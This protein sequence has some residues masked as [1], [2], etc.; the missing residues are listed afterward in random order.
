MNRISNPG[1]TFT[2]YYGEFLMSPL[3]LELSFNYCSHKCAFCFANLNKPDRHADVKATINLIGQYRQRTTLAAKLLQAG[4]ATVVSNRVD[5]FAVSNDRQ[6]LPV[7]EMMASAG[8][9]VA[10]QT[11][12]GRGVDEAL[13]FLAPSVWYVSIGTLSEDVRKRIEPGAPTIADR[14]DLIAK[15]KAKGHRVVVGT[16]P[17][18][19]EWCP[20]PGKLFAKCKDAGA[21]GVWI[22]LLHLN[23]E[24]LANMTPRERQGIGPE[25][26]A[27]ARKRRKRSDAAYFLDARETAL[28]HGLEV[29][30]GQQSNRSEFFKPYE[31]TYKATY[32]TLQGFLNWCHDHKPNGSLVTFE[33]FC[34][35]ALPMLPEGELSIGY[36]LG[37]SSAK[38]LAKKPMVNRMTFRDLLS[39]IWSEHSAKANLSRMNAFAFAADIHRDGSWTMLTDE[40]ARPLYLFSRDGF[41]EFHA[42]YQG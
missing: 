41:Q 12:G 40:N 18:L 39:V 10:L 28:D 31:E 33:E 23:D 20:D 17:L 16:N 21:E 24:Q 11:R 8:L 3:P 15:V 2:V 32:P 7:L 35:Y 5:P 27:V 34:A 29:F 13:A 25:A 30:S 37:A 42:Q 26:I 4:H 22:E 19:E 6:A 1:D 9:P 36:Y 38:L 14:F